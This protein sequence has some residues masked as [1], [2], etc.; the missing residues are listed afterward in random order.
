MAR[1]TVD[2]TADDL[3]T[4]G[5]NRRLE[6]ETDEIYKSIKHQI[7]SAHSMGN[8]EVVSELPDTFDIGSM[9]VKDIQLVVYSELIEKLENDG[10][11][12]FIDWDNS[13]HN[14]VLYVKWASSLSRP[15][16]AR[17]AEIIAKHFLKK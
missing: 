3:L 6:K 7:Y 14:T 15:E 11:T 4:L 17:R 16:R 13:E 10:F 1:S 12:V 5:P 2:L 9:Q 8:S